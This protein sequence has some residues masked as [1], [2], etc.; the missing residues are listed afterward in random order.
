MARLPYSKNFAPRRGA[1][2]V[3][4]TKEVRRTKY[5]IVKLPENLYKEIQKVAGEE[6]MTTSQIVVSALK[7][8]LEE[9]PD[10]L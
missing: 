2:Q 9:E 1:V 7:D 3:P 10:D 5:R 6:K 4:S 8:W